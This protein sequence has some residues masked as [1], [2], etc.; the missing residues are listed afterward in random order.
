MYL[1]NEKIWH[2]ADAVLK[3]IEVTP[4]SQK[5]KYEI[6]RDYSIEVFGIIPRT[7]AIF[8]AVKKADLMFKGQILRT[9][10]AIRKENEDVS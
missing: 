6:A 4:I 8:L 5:R 1:S 9:K 10:Q 3:T 7:S 2:M